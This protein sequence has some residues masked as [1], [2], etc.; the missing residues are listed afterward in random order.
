MVFASTPTQVAATAPSP[1]VP[2]KTD[3]P[4]N[5]PQSNGPISLENTSSRLVNIKSM[6]SNII[7]SYFLVND[8]Q[9]LSHLIFLVNSHSTPSTTAT[10][11][12]TPESA[13]LPPPNLPPIY[14][15][16]MQVQTKTYQL[17][18]STL[19]SQIKQYLMKSSPIKCAK[20]SNGPINTNIPIS[21]SQSTQSG[22][23]KSIPALTPPAST[24]TASPGKQTPTSQPNSPATTAL[25][26]GFATTQIPP[27]NTTANVAQI[28]ALTTTCNQTA[29]INGTTATSLESILQPAPPATVSIYLDF[30]NYLAKYMARRKMIDC[31]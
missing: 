10:T 6:L 28:D 9:F 2:R 3:F 11:A 20:V 4:S 25:P 22:L 7:L 14:P 26:N 19:I 12:S 13:S 27:V 31:I 18:H 21:S 1:T 17:N 8:L 24:G 5:V 23:V 30:S 29:G 15:A 16:S